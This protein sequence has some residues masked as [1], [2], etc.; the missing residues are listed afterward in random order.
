L[1]KFTAVAGAAA[2]A[3]ERG[4]ARTIF[5]GFGAAAVRLIA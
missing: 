2:M 3:V 1:D 4:C 5:C